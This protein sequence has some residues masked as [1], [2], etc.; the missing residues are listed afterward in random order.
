MNERTKGKSTRNVILPNFGQLAG[1]SAAD[2]G[3][4]SSYVTPSAHTKHLKPQKGPS[5]SLHP[6]DRSK[7]L[8]KVAS[9]DRLTFL[10]T[11]AHSL[12]LPVKKPCRTN[13]ANITQVCQECRLHLKCEQRHLNPNHSPACCNWDTCCKLIGPPSM[14]SKVLAW[15]SGCPAMIC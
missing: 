3:R 14:L 15:R 11:P 10:S 12:P 13:V 7:T 8:S 4:K 1:S 6:T 5:Y 9:D 2:N